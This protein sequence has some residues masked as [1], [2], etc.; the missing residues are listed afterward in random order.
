ME[1]IE[2]RESEAMIKR[3]LDFLIS[4]SKLMSNSEVND[5]LEEILTYITSLKGRQ[6][7]EIYETT[8]KRLDPIKREL[9]DIRQKVNNIKEVENASRRAKLC[10]TA[11]NYSMITLILTFTISILFYTIFMDY[12]YSFLFLE[13]VE[14]IIIFLEILYLYKTYKKI[15]INMFI[16]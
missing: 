16:E 3:T 9:D 15:D 13:I 8:I 5:L 2:K 4:L 14:T 1:E 7:K 6:W 12:I 11:L 10:Y